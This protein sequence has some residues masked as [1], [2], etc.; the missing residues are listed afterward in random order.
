MGRACGCSARGGAGRGAASRSV[1]MGAGRAASELRSEEACGATDDS[2]RFGRY[3]MG[4]RRVATSATAAEPPVVGRGAAAVAGMSPAADCRSCSITAMRAGV[5]RSGATKSSP[6][7]PALPIGITPPH[8]EQR[9]RIPASGTRLGSTRNTELH[10]PHR[11][12]MAFQHPRWPASRSAT[13]S[14]ERRPGGGPRHTRNP[15]AFWR[16]FSSR[17]PAR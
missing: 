3:S 12:F 11:T 17:S 1:G 10:S 2:G 5:T 6:I 8:T 4:A 9:A 14:P 16:S 7:A 15:V 13:R